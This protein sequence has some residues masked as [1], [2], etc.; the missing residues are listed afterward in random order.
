MAE[1]K[2]F[3]QK[4]TFL[5][6]APGA[7]LSDIADKKASFE[8]VDIPH[9]WLIYQTKDLYENSTGWYRKILDARELG[10][11]AGEHVIIRFDGVYMDSTLYVNGQSVGDWKYGYSAFQ[12]DITEFLTEGE[13]ELLLQVRFL[14]PNSRWYSGAGIYRDV[15]LKVYPKVY[16]PLDG[17]YVSSKYLPGGNYALEVETE[18]E[19]AVTEETVCHYKL[20]CKGELWQDLGWQRAPFTLKTEVQAPKE[21]DI[22]EPNCY[23]LGVYLYEKM[24]ADVTDIADAASAQAACEPV[25]SQEITIGFRRMEF[26][27]DRGFFLNGRYVKVN[28]VCEHHDFGCLGSVF[29]KEAMRRK[30]EVLRKMGVNALRT[31]HNM[32]ASALM[33][34]ADEMGF[35][36]LSEGFDMWERSKTEY[37]YGRFFKEWAERDVRSWIRRDRNHPSVFMWSIGNEI[38]DTHADAHG[39]EITRRLISYVRAHDPKENAPIT[40]GSNFMPWEGAQKCADIVKFAGYN[41]GEKLYEDHH[42]EHPDWIIYGSETASMVQSRGVYRFP[43]KQ[44]MMA[45]E[46]E[47]CSS[48]GNSSTSWGAKDVEICIYKDRDTEFSFGQFLWT[49]FDY[50]GEPTPYHTKNSYF[51]QVDTAGF[52]KDSYHV[53]QAEWTDVKKAPMVHLYPYWDF[54]EGQLIDVRA[55]TNGAKVELFVNGESKGVHTI[56]HK[57]GKELIGTWQVV[58]EPGEITAVAYDETGAEIARETRHSF[59]D[60]VK[61]VV[62]ADKQVLRSDGEDLAFLTIS[63]VDKDGYPVENAMNYAEVLVD[64]AGRLLGLDNGDSADYDEYKGNVRKLFNGKLM[65]VIGSKLEIGE[66]NITVNAKGLESASTTVQVKA[67]MARDGICTTENIMNRPMMLT[68]AQPVRRVDIKVCGATLL[69]KDCREV[70]L[71]ARVLP[72]NADDKDII[73]KVVNDNGIDI[74]Y[75]KIEP[76]GM[77]NGVSK[78]KVIA[79]G[80]GEFQVRCL[81]KSGTDKVKLI[82]QMNFT[83]EGMGQAFVSPYEFLSAGLYNRAIGDISNGNE[84]GIAT[85]RAGVSA[86]VFENLDFGEYGSDEITIPVFALDNDLHNIELWLGVPGEAGSELLQVL[87][88]QKPSVWNVYQEDIWKLEKRIKGVVTLSLQLHEKVHIKGFAFK[89]HEK[90]YSLLNAAECNKVYGDTFTVE[91]AAIVGIGNNVTVV[92]DNMNFGEQGAKGILLTGRSKLAGNTIHV[93]F[94][95][96]NGE[97][98][99]RVL[100][101]K[102]T[103]EYEVQEFGFDPLVGAGKIEFVFLPGSDFD[104]KS[105]IFIK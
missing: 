28:G 17:V 71:E 83:A 22:E 21:W 20:F 9:D 34:L 78:A 54:N 68:D 16:L 40:I 47:Q 82:S 11:A 5:K 29:Y 77:E 104:M 57:H 42:K 59:G 74:P 32:P 85:D 79:L 92:F 95:P 67:A 25:D 31:S 19:G 2:L 100:E 86:V 37:D 14:S 105:F 7:E 72:V 91:E 33:E 64:G 87:P 51:G 53:F 30:F 44:S 97:P 81:S 24:P 36:V 101:V 15:W 69:N 80:D 39:Q 96:E 35:L 93:L 13:N 75:A 12:F 50:I 99:R 52:P 10:L 103:E 48:I 61:L 70:L 1:I 46:D 98:V 102:G 84:K 3:N 6:T 62:E 4:W 55:C 65:A 76:L 63:A 66:V 90:A 43:L 88:Y 73:W 18:C 58:Y 23:K 38:Y 27:T 89:K 26:T 49:G 94:T 56:D 41:Y 60:A 45:D 8:P